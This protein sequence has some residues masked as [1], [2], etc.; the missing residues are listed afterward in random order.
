[1]I[2]KIEILKVGKDKN[3]DIPEGCIP[4]KYDCSM[5]RRDPLPSFVRTLTILRPIENIDDNQ[6]IENKEIEEKKIEDKKIEEEI[7]KKCFFC[8]DDFTRDKIGTIPICA[9]CLSKLYR[10][11]RESHKS[12]EC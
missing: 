1:M 2:Y 10:L 5:E 9:I 11:A 3:I 7:E 4:I 6:Y 12:L 8:E